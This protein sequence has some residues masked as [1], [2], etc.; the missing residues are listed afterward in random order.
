M[1]LLLMPPCGEREIVAIKAGSKAR[2]FI[3]F[4]GA[5]ESRLAAIEAMLLCAFELFGLVACV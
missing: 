2:D 1:C 3:L 5:E 4:I